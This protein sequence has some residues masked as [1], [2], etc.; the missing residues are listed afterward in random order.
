MYNSFTYSQSG[1]QDQGQG[2]QFMPGD[3]GGFVLPSMTAPNARGAL[4]SWDS[5]PGSFADPAASHMHQPPPPQWSGY[6]PPPAQYQQPRQ[7]PQYPPANS[8]YGQLPLNGSYGQLPL[9]SSYGQLPPN[10]SYSSPP[11]PNSSYGQLPPNSSYGQLP[12]NNSFASPPP[13]AAAPTT[14][15]QSR[16]QHQYPPQTQHQYSPQTQ[17]P[18]QYHQ[19]QP[20]YSSPEP[21]RMSQPPPYSP[22]DQANF[23]NGP[24]PS[25]YP[26]K[27]AASR[28]A[29]TASSYHEGAR[30]TYSNHSG[31]AHAPPS[32]QGAS[33]GWDGG[34]YQ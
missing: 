14:Y 30:S 20:A 34:R 11:P 28:M 21:S 9:N 25:R 5:A 24:A 7:Y 15:Y 8:S 27:R 31:L 33:Y 23:N 19:Q 18:P 17:Q 32:Y 10:G 16:G 2:S 12:P 1:F 29:E 6:S 3:P 26:G 22:E 4:P 13:I